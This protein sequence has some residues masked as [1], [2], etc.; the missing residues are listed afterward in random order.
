MV[1]K[2]RLTFLLL[3][4]IITM[5]RCTTISFHSCATITRNHSSTVHPPLKIN[6]SPIGSFFP[7][8]AP[9][10]QKHIFHIFTPSPMDYNA[11]MFIVDENNAPIV[12]FFLSQ[13]SARK[14][15]EFPWVR[16]DIAGGR[17]SELQNTMHI[18]QCQFVW[19][20]M[21]SI[22]GPNLWHC[23]S[24]RDACGPPTVFV[25]PWEYRPILPR[26]CEHFSS[27]NPPGRNLVGVGGG[28]AQIQ[29]PRVRFPELPDFLRSSGSETG[30]TQPREYNCGAAWKK[31]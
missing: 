4:D 11:I 20:N 7:R 1:S 10:S 9:Y 19:V 26:V 28:G 25:L 3:H 23:P 13:S 24:S 18:L 30:S 8:R 29:R 2:S 6:Y 5:S 27:L 16:S 22:S 14:T 17:S 31:K 15:K 21:C 12:S